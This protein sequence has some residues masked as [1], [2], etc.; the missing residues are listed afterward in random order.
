MIEAPRYPWAPLEYPEHSQGTRITAIRSAACG[1]SRGLVGYSTRQGSW[2]ATCS[3]AGLMVAAEVLGHA[4]PDHLVG[5]HHADGADVDDPAAHR[6]G[7]RDRR[8]SSSASLSLE[9]SACDSNTG[10]SSSG[11]PTCLSVSPS[12]SGF[13]PL[14]SVGGLRLA[15]AVLGASPTGSEPE[16][17]GSVVT[18]VTC[19]LFGGSCKLASAAGSCT[20]ARARYVS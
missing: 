2:C 19:V 6:R 15:T 1:L 13:R 4:R 16:N 5:Q 14:R 9:C 20:S 8:V 10:S 12:Q 17:V 7:P 11:R 18:T 3:P